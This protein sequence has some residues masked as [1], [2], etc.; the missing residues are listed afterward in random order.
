MSL[1]RTY[2]KVF[3][4][5]VSRLMKQ[6]GFKGTKKEA[7]KLLR[8]CSRKVEGST[9]RTLISTGN[10]GFPRKKFVKWGIPDGKLIAII[11]GGNVANVF[12]AEHGN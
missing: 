9:G 5:A 2:G 10:S 7:R 3:N 8:V 6:Y 11:N 12:E 1:H 4:Y